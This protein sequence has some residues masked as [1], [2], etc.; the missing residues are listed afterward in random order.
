VWKY[1]YIWFLTVDI[2]VLEVHSILITCDDDNDD[3][4]EEEEEE[5]EKEEENEK[6]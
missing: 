1:F 5:E 6:G 2:P 4:E 3:D